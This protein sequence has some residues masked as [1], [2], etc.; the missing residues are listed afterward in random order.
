M[1]A[2]KEL[3]LK[4]QATKVEKDYVVHKILR[5]V[6]IYVTRLFLVTPITSNQVTVISCFIGVLGGFL[7]SFGRDWYCLIGALLYVLFIILDLV[8]GE[9]ARYRGTIGMKGDYLDYLV[10]FF[11]AASLFGFLS[12]GVYKN[13]NHILAFVFGFLAISANLIDHLSSLLIYYS[14]CMKKKGYFNL[15][16]IILQKQNSNF[17]SESPLTNNTKTPL[18]YKI[19]HLINVNFNDVHIV[20]NLLIASI[21]N[22]LLPPVKI[23]TLQV[24]YVTIFLSFYGIFYPIVLIIHI[25]KIIF[26]DELSK[27]YRE[28]FKSEEESFSIKGSK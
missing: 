16:N 8:D 25:W 26:F 22:L 14:I 18:F 23:F 28:F 2:I 11:V 24:N 10:H 19:F 21:L 17:K 27:R 15:R 6:S 1:T 13:I 9:V 5:K 3:R 12:F 7:L 20:I 4:C